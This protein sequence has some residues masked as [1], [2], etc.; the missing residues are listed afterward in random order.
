[1]LLVAGEND[2]G[3]AK[4]DAR[5]L[6]ITKE[7]FDAFVQRHLICKPVAEN[8]TDMRA[9][10]LILDEQLRFLDCSDGGKKPSKSILAV[11]VAA[12]L[13][14]AG[15]D[16]DAYLRRGGRY[17]WSKA[18]HYPLSNYIMSTTGCSSVAGDAG[19]VP[20]I[21]DLCK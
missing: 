17:S 11:G 6:A 21:E 5:E 7:Q 20:D 15:F 19:Q 14:E 12:A 3:S 8:N 1:M 9:S 16:Q 13:V 10:Y 4:K 18:E 2:G